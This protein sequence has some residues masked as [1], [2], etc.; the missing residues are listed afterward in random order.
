MKSKNLLYSYYFLILIILM[1]GIFFRVVNLDKKVYWHDEIHTS[2]HITGFTAKEWHPS[3]FNGEVIT[4]DSL[5]YHLKINDKKSLADTINT[6]VF[7]DPHHPPLYYILV[8]YWRQF[9][10]DSIT[11][12]RSFSVLVSLWIFPAIYWLCWELFKQPIISSLCLALVAVSPLYVFYAQEAREYA[13]FTVLIALSTASLLRSIRLTKDANIPQER[14]YLS[15]GVYLILT[16][17]SLYTSL[18]SIFVIIAQAIYTLL[19][20]KNAFNKVTIFYGISLV[21]SCILFAPWMIVLI[22]N[23]EQ[24]KRANN[25]MIAV[26]LPPEELLKT[27]GLNLSRLFFDL[28]WEIDTLLTYFI[29][30]LCLLLVSYSLY[31]LYKKSALKSWLFVFSLVFIQIFFLLGPDLL[32]GGVRSLSPRYLIPFYLGINLS[33]AYLLGIKLT[34]STNKITKVW[35]MITI[36]ILSLGIISC[37]IN[38]QKDTAWTK[39]ISYSL[40]QVAQIINKIDSPLVISN[41]QGYH[42]GNIMALS[43]LLN[44]EVKFQLL[45]QEKQYKFP[46]GFQTIFLLSPTDEFKL[47][48]EKE[49]KVKAKLMFG[50]AYLKLWKIEV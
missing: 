15:W 11:V 46:K 14:C 24:Y 30:I 40:P 19:I 27:W 25:W 42:P 2:L 35:S 8:R 17:L 36:I 49:T 33:V 29:I 39:V 48:L 5:Q 43:Y 31:F 41:D 1:L 4:Q 28:G 9:W 12:I 45:S 16:T 10:G 34:H 23:Y 38:S 37:W 44:P 22:Q 32:W 50:D 26:T 6:L 47:T 18:F 3:L 7:D 21:I 13:L 20:E